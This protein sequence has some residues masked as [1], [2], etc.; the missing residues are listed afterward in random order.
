[1]RKERSRLSF[2]PERP[3]TFTACRLIAATV[4]TLCSDPSIARDLH[5]VPLDRICAVMRSVRD[6]EH[7]QSPGQGPASP[8]S[9]EQRHKSQH[10]RTLVSAAAVN[11]SCVHLYAQTPALDGP[12]PRRGRSAGGRLPLAVWQ[13]SVVPRLAVAHGNRPE[14]TSLIRTLTSAR[15]PSRQPQHPPAPRRLPVLAQRRRPPVPDDENN[16]RHLPTRAADRK[17]NYLSSEGKLGAIS[18]RYRTLAVSSA[19]SSRPAMKCPLRYLALTPRVSLRP[20]WPWRTKYKT[21]FRRAL[22]QHP[23]P[24]LPPPS[25]QA[26]FLHKLLASDDDGP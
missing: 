1:M 15:G 23:V 19:D 26:L 2:A 5:G 17:K 22:V 16:H 13:N 20:S 25:R 24:P 14:T 10:H 4:S 3:F 12:V 18:R 21:W 6:K 7:R 11:R 8:G 9:R